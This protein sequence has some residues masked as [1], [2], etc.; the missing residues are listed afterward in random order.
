M[1]VRDLSGSA[2]GSGLHIGVAM[3]TFN[4]LITEALLR[5]ALARL[6]KAGV[7][8]V[9]VVRVPGALELPLAAARLAQA[10]CRGVVAVGAVIEGETDH[11]RHVAAQSAAGLTQVSLERDIPVGNAILT[12]RQLSHARAR[13]G[14]G[15]GNRG[16][17]AAESV[18]ITLRALDELAGSSIDPGERRH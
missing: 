9:T 13:S 5:G 16:W 8:E 2:D 1:R 17:E 7:Q 14:E 12:V 10:G 3:S 18:L 6:E 11:Y 4:G 15:A